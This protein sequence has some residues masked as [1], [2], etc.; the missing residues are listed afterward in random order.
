MLQMA[1]INSAPRTAIIA[2]VINSSTSVN[3]RLKSDLA[4]PRNESKPEP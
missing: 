1:D 2:T 4:I 3:A